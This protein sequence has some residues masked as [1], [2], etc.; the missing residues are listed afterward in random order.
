MIRMRAISSLFL[1][2][3]L[4]TGSTTAQDFYFGADLSYVNQMEDCGADFK[5][6]N[7]SK[8]VYD[9]FADHGTNLVRVRLWLDPSWWQDSLNQPAGVLPHYNDFPDVLETLQ[10]ARAKGMKTML[11]LHYS[12]FW[13]DPQR[14]LIPRAWLGAANNLPAL[15]DS[16]YQYTKRTLLAL[17]Q[18]GLMPDIVKVGNE[19]N[20]G[21]LN[22]IPAPNSFEVQTTVSTDWQRHGQLYNEAIRAVREVGATA[23]I[24]PKIAVHFTNNL[25][26]QFWNMHNL[27][28]TAGVTDFDIFG[29]SYYY[30]WHGSSLGVLQSTLQQLKSSF[31]NYDV[32]VV[33]T[34]YLWSED[35]YD[36]LGNI[37]TGSDPAYQPVSPER[38]LH[39]MLDY[40]RA[41]QNAGGIGVIFW[42]PA[43]VSTPCNTPWGV[44]S[45]HD[46][47]AFFSPQDHNFIR[48]GAGR[49]AEAAWYQPKRSVTFAVDMSG[50][51]V[52]NGVYITGTFTGINWQILP[53][54]LW[55]DK[56][57]RY[58]TQLYPGHAGAYYFLRTPS[59][60]NYLNFRETV[61]A[62]CV[63]W[64][65]TDRGFVVPHR[66]TVFANPWGSCETFQTPS[67]SSKQAS[68][69]AF[70]ISPV[71]A[72]DKVHILGEGAQEIQIQ[73]LDAT[74]RPLAVPVE[75][76]SNY[77]LSIDVSQLAPGIYY[78]Q[79]QQNGEI[80]GGKI[81]VY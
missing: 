74:G 62:P 17:N 80:G 21:I 33:E 24:N 23:D 70:T 37:I 11:D 27:I 58:S 50:Q 75:S 28:N 78:V 81:V 43:W 49:W 47:V 12:D 40:A 39:Y 32:M 16:V 2:A 9:I 38:Q 72:D 76:R 60:N 7:Q 18:L 51:D 6:N 29:I 71:P 15:R 68:F 77:R 59:W 8:D 56:V 41:V 10:R 36:Q 5:E 79:F 64:W 25:N 63:Q 3:L 42:E 34:G 30:A 19:N 52:S 26:G 73:L 48:E 53:M 20:G 31:P 1:F 14:Q 46:H 67:V 54:Q 44:G 61:P 4:F 65:N 66:D 57:Y 69:E 22:H 45:S 55:Y 13:A 35:N